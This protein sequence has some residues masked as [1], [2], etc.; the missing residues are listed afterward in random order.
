MRY[1]DLLDT[2]EINGYTVIIDKTWED[3]S[4]R[5]LFEEC[6]VDEICRKIDNGTYDWF[7]LRVRVLLRGHE[8]GSDFLGG[9]CYENPRECLTDGSAAS[10]IEQALHNADIER[11][12]LREALAA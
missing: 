1:W 10:I 4:P 12:A 11:A 6:D 7:M 2:R 5:Q 3:I 9:M 8:L